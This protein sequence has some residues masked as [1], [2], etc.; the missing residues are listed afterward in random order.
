MKVIT[1]STS[2]DPSHRFGHCSP[3]SAFPITAV[4]V[5]YQSRKTVVQALDA[6]RDAHSRNLLHCIVVDNASNDGTAECIANEHP[7]IELIQNRENMGFGRACNLAFSRVKSPYLLLINPDAV[8]EASAVERLMQFMQSHPAAGIA[9]PATLDDDAQP[10][11]AGM[12]VKPDDLLKSVLGN[13]TNA[14]PQRRPINPGDPPFQT[15]WVCG[16]VMMIRSELFR[17]LDGFDERFF[18]YFEE[19]DFCRRAAAIGAEIWAVGEAVAH[20]SGSVSAKATGD[21]LYSSCIAE[22]YL[23][24]RRRYLA[25]HFGLLRGLGTEAALRCIDRAHRLRKAVLH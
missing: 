14:Y 3:S 15:N 21:E 5:T 17:S 4:T 25:K 19:T 8:I 11:Y 9:A 6:A 18:L 10:H 20:H 16:A 12:M 2:T 23:R 13:H 24:S 22:H 1:K 7:W